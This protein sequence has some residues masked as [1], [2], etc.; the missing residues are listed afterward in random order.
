M[1][2]VH[3][4]PTDQDTHNHKYC[5][6]SR[7]HTRNRR[8]SHSHPHLPTLPPPP[9]AHTLHRPAPSCGNPNPVIS[10]SSCYFTPDLPGM[11]FS[12]ARGG[13]ENRANRCNSLRHMY[14]RWCTVRYL[15]VALGSCKFCMY[16]TRTCST[17]QM[18]QCRL[19]TYSQSRYQKRS[20]TNLDLG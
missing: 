19:R 8:R 5:S 7:S 15:V 10:R 13:M 12:P 11:L 18:L 17:C 14:M 6:R 20:K 3:R 9:I 4:Q 1:W 16:H 2:Y